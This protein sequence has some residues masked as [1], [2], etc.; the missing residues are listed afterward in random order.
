LSTSYVHR[1]F[2]FFMMLQFQTRKKNERKHLKLFV[3]SRYLVK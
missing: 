2:L 1:D 3:A